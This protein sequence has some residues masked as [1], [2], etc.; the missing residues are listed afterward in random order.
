MVVLGLNTAHSSCDLA[1]LADGEIVAAR[2][3]DQGT[4][5]DSA[6]AG[7]VDGLFADAGLGLDD[8]SRIGVCSGPGSFTG[9]RIGV[10]YARG[11]ALVLGI[12]CLGVS[13][14][15]AC[16]SA[17]DLRSP[18]RVALQ[19]KKRPPEITFWTQLVD[20]G[21]ACTPPAEWPLE[22]FRDDGS[23]LA[24]DRPEQLPMASI[25]AEPKA[26]LIARWAS[27]LDPAQYPPTPAYVRA[28]D[29]ALPGGKKA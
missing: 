8:L 4:G 26:P 9:V 7:I 3:D 15:M 22:A 5:Q 20:A 25:T 10:A 11:L 19:A 1:L 16:V 28:P 12:P 24:A 23:E 18:V 21:G 2:R 17:N 13:S 29:A 6:L 27:C 14:L